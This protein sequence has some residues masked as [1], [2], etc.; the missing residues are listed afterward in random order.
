VE[1]ANLI[2]PALGLL[3]ALCILTAYG[4]RLLGIQNN[5][6][7]YTAGITAIVALILAVI[8]AVMVAGQLAA[9]G[10]ETPPVMGFHAFNALLVILL[11]IT[12][13][14]LG[15][16]MW[17]RKPDIPIR[18]FLV[19]SIVGPLLALLVIVQVVLGVFTFIGL[20]R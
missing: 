11:L 20:V 15:I 2:H 19:H 6:L 17:S 7:H 1:L 16:V 4:V 8:R 3:A 10:I 12:Q 18:V 13:A 9:L 14:T 5:A